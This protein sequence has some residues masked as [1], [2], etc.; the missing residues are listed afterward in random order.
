MIHRIK[1]LLALVQELGTALTPET[2]QRLLFLFCKE[3][4]EHNHYYEFLMLSS[5]PH[6]LQAE[7][8]LGYLVHKGYLVR[9]EGCFIATDKKRTATDLDFFEKIGIQKLKKVW[10][11]KSAEEIKAYVVDRYPVP[12][13]PQIEGHAL[14][15]I[16]YEG[17]S[18]EAYINLLLDNGVKLLCDVRRNP[19]SKKFGFSKSEL[20]KNLPLVGTAYLHMPELGIASE[21]RQTL[22]TD[23]DYHALFMKYEETTLAQRG[24]KLTE[25]QNLL[26]QFGR[27]AITCFEADVHHC[28]RNRVAR[29]MPNI[30]NFQA[31]IVHL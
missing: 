15:T 13:M 23:A 27:I 10:A 11:N 29:A 14:F 28:H 21:E 6:S 26:T 9:H 20:A 7:A 12:P 3:Y 31:K 8:D 25:L 1:L 18:P 5:G 19:L 4:I 24:D 16:G 17:R 2:L 30:P 22:Q